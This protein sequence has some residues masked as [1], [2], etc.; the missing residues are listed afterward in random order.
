[1]TTV[2]LITEVGAQVV[3]RRVLPATEGAFAPLPANLPGALAA[4]LDEAGITRLYVHQRE[5]IDAIGS[6]ENVL[7]TTG[8]ASGKSL[9]YQ[10]PALARQLQDPAA[11]VLALYPTKALAHDQ[12][13]SLSPL[14][15]QAGLP[16]DSVAGYDGDTPS[17]QR[18]Q[19][20]SA[21]RTLITNPDMLHAGILPHHTLWRRFLGG[22]SL[23][24]VDEIHSYRGVFGGHIA[25]VLRRL[26]RVARH[27]GARPSF[28]LT[29]ATLGNPSEHARNLTGASVR[30]VDAD[31]APHPERELLLVQPP[32]VNAE[33]GLRG[34]PLQEAVRIAHR[35]VSSGKQVLVFAGSRQGAEEAVLGLRERVP[36]VR[37]YRSGLLPRERRAIEEEL[38]SGTARGV[39]STNALEL[40]VDV[41]RVDAVVVAGYPGSAAAFRQQVGRAGRSGRPGAG[42]LVLGGGPLDQYLARHPEHLFGASSER[43]LIDPDHLLIA[44]DHMRCAAFEL[45]V[46][47]HE[48]F[49]GYGPE[50]VSLLLRQLQEE[51]EVH[52]SD[53]RA[54]WLGQ[55]YPAQDVGLRS[56]GNDQVTLLSDGNTVGSLDA[57]SARWMAHEGAVYLHDGEPFLVEELDLD[58]R[59]AR[60]QPTSDR[61][62]TRATRETRIDPAGD[63]RKGPVPGASKFEGEVVVTDRV[64]GYRRVLRHTFETLGRYPLDLEPTTLLTAAYGFA[65]LEDTVETLRRQGSWSNDANDYGPDWPRTRSAAKTRDGHRCQ[66]CGTAEGGGIVLHVHHKVPFRAFAGAQQANRLENLTTLCPGCHRQAEQG[67]RVR[68]GLAATAYALRSLAPLLVMCDGRD[69]GVHADPASTLADGAPALVIFETVPGGVGL[70]QELSQRHAEL[71]RAARDLVADCA[72]EDGCPSCVGPAGELGHAGK[73]EA[74][75][76][77]EALT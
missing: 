68:S 42:I 63:L 57:P 50:E 44:L 69:L 53:G 7:L 35:L 74:L 20:R 34:P 24:V 64:T 37:S 41:G 10:L 6:G 52:V 51:G 75:A 70:A 17:S 43:A 76:L 9:A 55:R 56:A 19:V 72:C 32:L 14:A 13:R 40:G 62:L 3:G 66:A 25:G 5:A 46:E 59:V 2:G 8:T 47:A 45:P 4:A 54:Y 61:Y 71:V 15:V 48:S 38:R 23:I 77:L 22:L 58:R 33:L 60:L 16:G 49:G 31:S 73:G 27:Y 30:H 36:G 21:V 65:P 12:A 28:V 29:S 26:V 11:T 1:M 67:V 18:P 39:M